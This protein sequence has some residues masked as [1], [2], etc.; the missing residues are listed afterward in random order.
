MPKQVVAEDVI[1]ALK[2]G[3]NPE[4]AI[5][6]LRFF[7]AGPGE[8]AAGDQFLG[9]T[10]PAQRKIASQY[11]SLSLSEI[12]IL[13]SNPLHECRLTA[14]FILC[15]Q[16]KDQKKQDEIVA[17][18]LKNLDHVNNWDLVDSSA[19]HILGTWLLTHDTVILQELAR[20]N[21]LWRQRVA[22]VSTLAFIRKGRIQ[23]TLELAEELITHTHDLIHKASG[24]MLREAFKKDPKVVRDFL[25]LHAPTMPRTMLRYTIE[26]MD[27]QE[28][29]HYL[30]LK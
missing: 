3:V 27:K 16:M 10:V 24:W 7:K 23:P 22:M 14:L 1:S 5:H 6:S 15:R 18:Y 25:N 28:R 2:K 30:S 12:A 29:A 11:S 4:R 20:S 8:Y 26:L 13:L 17:F 19:Y 21:H 9:L